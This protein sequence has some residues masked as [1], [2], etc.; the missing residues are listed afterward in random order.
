M[1]KAEFVS[2]CGELLA[3]AKPN[4]ISC[5]LRLGKDIK[6]DTFENYIPD[7]EYVVVTCANG[8]DYKLPISATNLAG[9]A[10]TI[11]NKMAYK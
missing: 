6:E 2:K 10:E 7:A 9:I 5:E 4:L 8:Y 3:V 11:F 1:N